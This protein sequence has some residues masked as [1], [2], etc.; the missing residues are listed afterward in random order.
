MIFCA[1]GEAFNVPPSRSPRKKPRPAFAVDTTQAGDTHDL[2]PPVFDTPGAGA[3]R[4]AAQFDNWQKI[5]PSLVEPLLQLQYDTQFFRNMS[6]VHLGEDLP[7]SCTMKRALTI[8]VIRMNVRVCRC[9]AST[10]P[11]ILLRA[12]LF[13]CSPC[14][15]TL[16][17][18][19][20]LLDFV[21]ELFL[22]MA[23][24]NTA[25][26]QTL[27]SLL[28]RRGFKLAHRETLRRRFANALEWY[29]QLVLATRQHVET[30]LDAARSTIRE[31][32]CAQADEPN[33]P[34]TPSV[35]HQSPAPASSP[36]RPNSVASPDPPSGKKRGKKRARS[37]E[38]S[39]DETPATAPNPFHDPPPLT[40]PSDYLVSRCPACFGGLKHDDTQTFDVAVCVDGNFTQKRR[41]R[42]G[43]QDPPKQHPNSVFVP[44][45]LSRKMDAYVNSIRPAKGRRRKKARKDEEDDCYEGS[46]K[47]PR[48]ALDGCEA[49]FKAADEKLEKASTQ[50]FADTGLMA[51]LCRHDRVLWLV[52]MQSAG[53]KQFYVLLLLE[54]LFQHLPIDILVGLLYDIACKT[55]RSCILFGFLRRYLHRLAWAVSVF[56]AYAHTWACQVIYH[57]LKCV[58]FGFTNGE[59]AERFWFSIS[60]LIA[61]LRVAGFHH[62]LFTIDMQVDYDQKRSL[63]RFG[64]WLLRRTLNYEEK[65]REAKEVLARCEISEDRLRALWKEQVEFQTRPLPR[66][67]KN[68]GETAIKA[69]LLG[70]KTVATLQKRLASLKKKIEARGT[71]PDEVASA[72]CAVEETRETIERQK[73]S[74]AR[75]LKQ[76]ETSDRATL[77]KLHYREYFSTKLSAQTL[78]ARILQKITHRKLE[79]DP[80]ERSVRPDAL[81]EQKKNTHASAAIKKREPTIRKLVAT[82]NEECSKLRK[83]IDDRKA[84]KGA[85]APE[86]L[87]IEGIFKLDVDDA[88]WMDW[89]LLDDQDT[90]PPDWY[91]SREVR[92]GIRALLTKD[93][94]AEDAHRLAREHLHLRIWFSTE[95]AAVQ[96]AI[97]DTEEGPLQSQLVRRRDEL[98]QLHVVWKTSLDRLSLD[99][100]DVPP[101]GPTSEELLQSRYTEITASVHRQDDESYV[102]DDDEESHEEEED[103]VIIAV[104]AAVERADNHRQEDEEDAADEDVTI[105]IEDELFFLSS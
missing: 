29:T 4:R 26:C 75:I 59:G 31:T 11:A 76:L 46:L 97:A 57:P 3:R 65:L 94:C 52:N 39:D 34:S 21:M 77:R 88:I 47:V 33:T 1:Y 98:L 6:D 81:T 13:P 101:W 20:Q 32:E 102:S 17:V 37:C 70:D 38:S 64:S 63:L 61:Y 50:F 48:S 54:M 62:R 79:F 42:K 2:H 14:H 56:H 36:P 71:S 45:E 92:D 9:P 99:G 5:L 35:V 86:H 18:D 40:R 72:Q 82:F 87:D 90:P 85:I 41:K 68:Q 78:R 44:E 66:R 84:P 103:E 69:V 89:A 55:N 28:D 19:V 93:R 24:N 104:L 51:L 10:A 105:A 12:G 58:G 7:C 67:S 49:S 91:T 74:S 96:R 27:E 73:T 25:F 95:W 60:N 83:L 22:N 16:A 43:G 30:T 23:P 80:I 8:A 15:P 100:M 53:E